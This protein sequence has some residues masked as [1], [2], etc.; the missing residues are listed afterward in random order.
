MMS[1]E[2]VAVAIFDRICE[3]MGKRAEA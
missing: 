2:N 1:K 3:L